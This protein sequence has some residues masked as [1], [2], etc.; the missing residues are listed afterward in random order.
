MNHDDVL[1]YREAWLDNELDAPTGVRVA[2]H[3]EHC[4][5]C[6]SWLATRHLLQT[7]LRA[8]PLIHAMPAALI[9]K[10]EALVATRWLGIYRVPWAPALAAT[11]LA[12]VIGIGIGR[13]WGPGLGTAQEW[14]NARV[15]ST[16]TARSVDI[17]SSSHHTVK[18]W[19]SSHLPFSPPVPEM[20]G[21]EEQLVGGRADF[22][23]GTPMA[24]LVYQHGHHQVD[25][26]LWPGGKQA[27]PRPQSTLIDGFRVV[28]GNSGEFSTVMVSDMNAAELSDF[29]NRWIAA[30]AAN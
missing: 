28:S 8:V 10:T 21:P 19:L 26:F 29:M 9:D 16:L 25:V 12:C 5:E 22:V 1:N 23:A 15:R 13:E 7:S 3:L 20:S 27:A 2:A 24:T 17:E 11:V 14:V 4:A 30:A 18:P 6:G